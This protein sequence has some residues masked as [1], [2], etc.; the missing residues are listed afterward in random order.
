MTAGENENV[1]VLVPEF[2]CESEA[3]VSLV[4][5]KLDQNS[6]YHWNTLNLHSKSKGSLE[7]NEQSRYIGS[8]F[9]FT[10]GRDTMESRVIF[11]KKGNNIFR[12]YVTGLSVEVKVT[13]FDENKRSLPLSLSEGKVN[14]WGGPR[15]AQ[16]G[17]E[18]DFY[19]RVE[20]KNSGELKVI[21]LN[22]SSERDLIE[23]E[24]SVKDSS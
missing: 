20:W 9:P 22:R 10:P 14:E 12:V 13:D 17:E 8:M 5:E 21:Y 16:I 1:I 7:V 2:Y 24:F 15:E 3:F 23:V 18:V 4:S 19:K 6:S 11:I